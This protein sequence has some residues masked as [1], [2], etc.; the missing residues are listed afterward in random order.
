M[1]DIVKWSWTNMKTY[2]KILFVLGILICLAG[3]GLMFDG[4]ILGKT[5]GNVTTV[6]GITGMRL[7]ATK[8]KAINYGGE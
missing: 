6:L 5:T 2:K 7:I 1:L 3:A 4:A 8:R